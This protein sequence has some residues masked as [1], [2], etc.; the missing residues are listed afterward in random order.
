MN[1]FYLSIFQSTI[2]P[3]VYLKNSIRMVSYLDSRWLEQA[4]IKDSDVFKG[5]ALLCLVTGD[6]K[7][8]R[9]SPQYFRASGDLNQRLFTFSSTGNCSKVMWNLKIPSISRL[10]LSHIEQINPL[11]SSLPCQFQQ[12]PL[13][14]REM[15]A[16]K[17]GHVAQ[18][19]SYGSFST[20]ALLIKII[21]FLVNFAWWPYLLT[22]YLKFCYV[23][24]KR[25]FDKACWLTCKMKWKEIGFILPF[26]TL[27]RLLLF[28]IAEINWIQLIG[29]M[30]L[31]FRYLEIQSLGPAFF[32][33]LHLNN[34]LKLW[35]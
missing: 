29:K 11:N 24:A 12:T 19:K 2:S 3:I 25:S 35:P 33:S 18:I 20:I 15:L 27:Q 21:G 23:S 10:Q 30:H 1:L 32:I 7:C 28:I 17:F 9:C 16:F 26:P 4:V 22:I 5:Y 13:N 8:F 14:G 34:V 31:K 6:K